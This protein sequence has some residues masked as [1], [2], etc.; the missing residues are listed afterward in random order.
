MGASNASDAPFSAAAQRTAKTSQTATQSLKPN[1]NPAS[2]EHQQQQQPRGP[3]FPFGKFNGRRSSSS[4]VLG[5]GGRQQDEAQS[6]PHSPP[7]DHLHVANASYTAAEGTAIAVQAPSHTSIS[8]TAASATTGSCAKDNGGGA[9]GTTTTTIRQRAPVPH[10]Q[11]NGHGPLQDLKRFLNHHLPNGPHHAHPPAPAPSVPDPN[12]VSMASPS[13]ATTPSTTGGGKTGRSAK[14]S[15]DEKDKPSSGGGGL[16]GIIGGRS[17]ATS[18]S[19]AHLKHVPSRH[20]EDG[21]EKKKEKDAHHHLGIHGLKFTPVHP[22]SDASVSAYSHKHGPSGHHNGTHTPQ[23]DLSEATHAPMGKKYGKWGK[24]LGS[25]A[26]GTVRLIKGN[27]KSGGMIYAVKEFRPKRVGE[28]MREYQKK[29][30]AEFCVGSTL[31]HVNI[32]ETVDI[33]SDHGHYYE[34]CSFP[35]LFYSSSCSL[36]PLWPARSWST[37]RTTCSVLS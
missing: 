1:P 7:T 15:D 25:G 19:S 30:T 17:R 11:S 12:A 10:P 4:N 22:P 2:T 32:I 29:V 21:K 9:V 6:A 13:G 33:V 28:S 3:G 27:A 8:N 31:K 24:V 14:H 26:G 23:R 5:P 34:V 35:L 16:K 36:A 18:G 37:P 20:D